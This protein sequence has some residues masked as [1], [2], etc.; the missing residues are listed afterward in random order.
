MWKITLKYIYSNIYTTCYQSI[1]AFLYIYGNIYSHQCFNDCIISL[2]KY[3]NLE[4]KN[5]LL[6][7]KSRKIYK[8]KENRPVEVKHIPYFPLSN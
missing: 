8:F 3:N 4:L 7:Y 2:E 1:E 5:M 6:T